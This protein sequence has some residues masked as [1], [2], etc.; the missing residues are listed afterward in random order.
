MFKFHEIFWLS[1][2][3][4]R[5]EGATTH[6][7][8]GDDI[9]ADAA[10]VYRSMLQLAQ[11]TG[12]PWKTS[13][14]V[15]AQTLADA[16]KLFGDVQAEM[17]EEVSFWS[18]DDPRHDIYKDLKKVKCIATWGHCRQLT[19]IDAALD[20]GIDPANI[21]VPIVETKYTNLGTFYRAQLHENEEKNVG[22]KRTTVADQIYALYRQIGVVGKPGQE[23]DV[24]YMLGTKRGTTQ[25]LWALYCVGELLKDGHDRLQMD[26]PT[27]KDGKVYDPAGFIPTG[28]DREELM[29]SETGLLTPWLN[30]RIARSKAKKDNRAELQEALDAVREKTQRAV[31]NYVAR[32]VSATVKRVAP[33]DKAA[34]TTLGGS[35][36]A[37]TFGQAL[38]DAVA[39]GKLA[40]S[41]FVQRYDWLFSMELGDLAKLGDAVTAEAETPAETPAEASAEA[42][43]EAPAKAPAKAKPKATAKK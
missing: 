34:W 4:Y 13:E 32:Y 3:N 10:R 40:V 12:Q 26:R 16:N 2:R 36:V 1:G 11:G 38:C 27:G 23:S 39:D 8:N 37:G 15:E 17:L 28:L 30:A 25:K 24:S 14:V 29:H 5:K 33:Q 18:P 42:S 20:A 31:E 35:F 6:K 43:A 22:A 21:V 9:D 7:P 19:A 41:A